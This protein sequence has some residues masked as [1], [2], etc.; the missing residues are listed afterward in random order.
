MTDNDALPKSAIK[1]AS[2]TFGQPTTAATT[3][4]PAADQPITIIETIE[5]MERCGG[6]FAQALAMAYLRAD[7]ENRIRIKFAFPELFERYR[8]VAKQL[9]KAGRS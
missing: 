8:S 3:A 6:S 2:K 4:A 1:S 9:R 5:A 7:P